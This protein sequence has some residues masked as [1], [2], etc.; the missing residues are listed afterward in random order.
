[1]EKPKIIPVK[2]EN[3]GEVNGETAPPGDDDDE[4]QVIVATTKKS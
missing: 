2:E 3:G 1:M 4:W